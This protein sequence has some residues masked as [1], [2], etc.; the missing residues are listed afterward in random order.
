M[1]QSDIHYLGEKTTLYLHD[2][3]AI[4]A[5]I[6][7]SGTFYE[8]EILHFLKQNFPKQRT[9]IDVGANIGNHA[10]FFS[11]FLS[12]DR[13]ICFEPF[14]PNYE[15]L[16]KNT[17]HVAELHR[18]ALGANERTTG[19][20]FI[21]GN[22]GSPFLDPKVAGDTVV[23][24]LDSFEFQDVSLLKIDVEIHYLEV[25]QG[26]LNTIDRCRPVIV[27]EGKFDEIYPLLVPYGYAAVMIWPQFAT[28][29]F[30]RLFKGA[31]V[32]EVAPS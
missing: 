28:Y 27:V 19:M 13:L 32:K 2:N 4:S 30:V 11:K 23:K 5:I 10:L 20:S 14:P 31:G 25:L 26:C 21:R 17:V 1:H 15:L 18:V 24:T 29:C 3:E 8:A 9:I 7:Q 22:L 16:E 12:P 6:E